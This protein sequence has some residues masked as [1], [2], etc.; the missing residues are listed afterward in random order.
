MEITCNS[1]GASGR[2]PTTRTDAACEP[3]C[4]ISAGGRFH[5]EMAACSLL[6]AASPL[7]KGFCFI[8]SALYRADAN[9]LDVLLLVTDQAS[10]LDQEESHGFVPCAGYEESAWFA[11]RK[12]VV[13]LIVTEDDEW[14]AD[15]AKA[16]DVCK[17]L[18][19]AT[20]RERILVYRIV[21]DGASSWEAEA[22]ASEY[23]DRS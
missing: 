3:A 7:V 20:K 2:N 10:F 21:R 17:V 19:L 1:S 8:G 12:G 5:E 9:D 4:G 16:S 23:E 18:R 6:Y 15:C 11:L 22:A 14:Y 13:N